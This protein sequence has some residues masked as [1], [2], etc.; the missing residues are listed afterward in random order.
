MTPELN[1]I[2][3][4]CFEAAEE[5]QY[6]PPHIPMNPTPD[7]RYMTLRF[8]DFFLHPCGHPVSADELNRWLQW[9]IPFMSGR[10]RYAYHE[11]L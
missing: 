11:N 5:V 8:D 1:L 10:A 3:S 6:R 4:I 2:C 9:I 7:F